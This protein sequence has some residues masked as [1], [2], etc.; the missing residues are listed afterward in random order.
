MQVKLIFTRKVLHL[1]SSCFESESFGTLKYHIED[2]AR[3]RF[4][5]VNKVGYVIGQRD[6]VTYMPCM[7]KNLL[8]QKKVF[9]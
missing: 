9:T 5:W 3:A 1:T 8:E 7:Y 6:N 4:L 2:N